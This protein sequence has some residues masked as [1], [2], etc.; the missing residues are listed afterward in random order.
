MEVIAV[1]TLVAVC[2]TILMLF[3]GLTRI[4]KLSE[5]SA[6]IAVPLML[7]ASAWFSKIIYTAIL[8]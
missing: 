4:C 2:L 5:R 3:A 8:S 7:I 1:F 6:T